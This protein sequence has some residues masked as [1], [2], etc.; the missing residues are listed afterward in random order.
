MIDVR[1]GERAAALSAGALFFCV[2]ASYFVLR[3]VRDALAIDQGVG[4][5]PW[6]FTA[7]CVTMLAVAPVWGVVV[8]RWPRRR[9]VPIAYHAFVVQLIVLWAMIARDVAPGWIEPVF[10][11]WVSVFNLFVVSVFWSL[12]A[13]VFTSA[14][15]RRLFGPIAAGGTCGALVGPTLTTTLVERIGVSGMLLVAAALLEVGVVCALAL[16]RTGRRFAVAAPAADRPV[17][18]NPFAGLRDVAANPHLAKIAAYVLCTT[19][20]ATFLYFQQGELT[21]A[22]FATREERTAFFADL[23]LWTNLGVLAVQTI[24][25]GRLLGWVGVGAVLAVLPIAQGLG[26]VALAAAPTIAILV[27]VQVAGRTATHALTR[28]SRELLFTTVGR[29]DKYKTKNVIDTLVYR[30]GDMATGWLYALLVWLGVSRAGLAVTAL[31]LVVIWVALAIALG[32][33]HRRRT[34]AA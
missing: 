21:H 17:G 29:E 13:D 23:D 8:A 5:L 2:L 33:A 7:T 9:F 31:P 34:T 15:G 10:F 1:P 19:V 6:L 4:D 18:G 28:P 11:V 12:C 27:A 32:R 22:S 30:A 14:Q 25:T 24:V 16:D 20:A 3:P 26:L